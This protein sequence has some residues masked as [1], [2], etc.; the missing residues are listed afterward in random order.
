MSLSKTAMIARAKHG[1]SR[2]VIMFLYL[3][4]TLVSLAHPS[5]QAGSGL[6]P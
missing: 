2:F 5:R 3:Y 6:H 1:L 4:L